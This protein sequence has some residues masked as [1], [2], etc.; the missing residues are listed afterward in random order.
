MTTPVA[1]RDFTPSTSAR[2]LVG[3][4]RE[5]ELL[6]GLLR[7]P[8]GLTAVSMSGEPGI[9]KT[10][11]LAE[12]RLDAQGRGAGTVLV[13]GTADARSLHLW[14]L[15]D[16]TEQLAAAL[17]LAEATCGEVTGLLEV[18]ARDTTPSTVGTRYRVWDAVVRLLEK[19]ADSVPLL[20]GID[21]AHWADPASTE[22]LAHLLGRRVDAHVAL[23]LCHRPRQTPDGLARA[24]AEAPRLERFDLGP[25][26]EPAGA[27]LVGAPLGSAFA[28]AA[29]NPLYLLA[30][31]ERRADETTRGAW[32]RRL[33]ADLVGAPLDTRIVAHAAA[34][35]GD[36]IPIELLPQVAELSRT[37]VVAALDQL[38]DDDLI[39]SD[40]SGNLN[41]RHPL[42]AR[43]VYDDCPVH[44][45]R[46]AHSRS[47]TA[48][49]HTHAP[50][51]A[52][53]PHLLRSARVGDVDAAA[54]LAD[55]AD[56]LV[57]PDAATAL[58]WYD[59]ALSLLPAQAADLRCR[60]AYSRARALCLSGRLSEGSVALHELLDGSLPALPHRQALALAAATHRLLGQY[61]QAAALL[62]RELGDLGVLDP[63][64]VGS[65]QDRVGG[66]TTL[67][68]QLAA[69]VLA[70]GKWEAAR[71]YGAAAVASA[72]SADRP[73]RAAAESIHALVLCVAGDMPAA[74]TAGDRAA[75]LVDGLTD[76]ELASRPEAALWT[77]EAE[78]CLTRY[79]SGLRHHQRAI[80]LARGRG[81]YPILAQLLLGQARVL[82]R[83]GHLR[84]AS[85]CAEEACELASGTG[86]L[87]L[88]WEARLGAAA[89]STLLGD[90]EAAQRLGRQVGDGADGCCETPPALAKALLAWGRLETGDARGC[91]EEVLASAGGPDLP[92]IDPLSRPA[93]YHVLTRA[94]VAVDDV[95]AAKCWVERA[96]EAASALAGG[97]GT[98][99]AFT[100]LAEA[101]LLQPTGSAPEAAFAAHEARERFHSA[102]NVLDAAGAALLAGQAHAASGAR[103]QALDALAGAEAS[104][105]HCGAM[106]KHAE[107][108]RELRRLGRRVPVHGD[109][110]QLGGLLTGREKEVA[111]LV[112]AGLTNREIGGELYL[113]EK[114]VERHLSHLFLKLRVS[115]RAAVAATMTQS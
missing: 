48:L 45:L 65:G 54:A 53:A 114:T 73:S 16:L 25:L 50:P 28:A 72:D 40:D 20:V 67:F 60:V 29:G 77:A 15:R 23:V 71:R 100:L 51:A 9:G 3:R 13:R 94:A 11:L 46:E 91:Q 64:R 112:A 31:A 42:V 43:A 12:L 101:E 30:L 102:G 70:Q 39:R 89:T 90:H 59:R 110:G 66:V 98:T 41:F 75:V 106:S 61:E 5:L 113:S 52:Q 32:S 27:Q 82:T 58:A 33:S 57:L 76:D 103:K 37:R 44:W 78:V 21:D 17:P 47:A 107:T 10:R 38:A 56:D 22:F 55:A 81:L 2:L 84:S 63:S 97:V 85:R 68:V 99:A 62:R 79:R 86:S 34:V 105:L 4:E 109:R 36:P 19:V 108:V 35:L 18:L 24:M 111:R 88:L 74:R 87:Y 49:R 14:L 83:L 93:W 92:L 1:G 7:R 69:T 6:K 95:V 96:R 80:D 26:S 8:R 104:F 115:N